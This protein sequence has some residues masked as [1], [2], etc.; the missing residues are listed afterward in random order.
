[1]PKPDLHHHQLS[2]DPLLT[3]LISVI[4]DVLK[5]PETWDLPRDP[6]GKVQQVYLIPTDNSKNREDWLEWCFHQ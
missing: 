3:D 5:Q 1:M 4:K 6:K 2:Q